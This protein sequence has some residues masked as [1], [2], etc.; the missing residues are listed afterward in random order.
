MKKRIVFCISLLLICLFS[1]FAADSTSSPSSFYKQLPGMFMVNLKSSDIYVSHT[2]NAYWAGYTATSSVSAGGYYDNQ[3]IAVLGIRNATE[4]VTFTVSL[5][6]GNGEWVYLLDPSDNTITRP[7]GIDLIVKGRPDNYVDLYGDGCVVHMGL[8]EAATGTVL[9]PTSSSGKSTS[10]T[11]PASKL[12]SYENTMWMDV[13]LVLPALTDSGS[14]TSSVTNKTYTAKSSDT[15]YTATLKIKVESGDFNDEYTLDLSGIYSSSTDSST[16]YTAVMLVTPTAAAKSLDIAGMAKSGSSIT[17]ANF[18]F[19]TTSVT[20]SDG[21]SDQDAYIFLSSSASG[22]TSGEKFKLRRLRSDGSYSPDDSMYNS[23]TYEAILKSTV[24][25]RTTQVAFDGTTSTSSGTSS[26][27]PID[28]STMTDHQN[29][30]QWVRWYDEGEILIHITQ[31]STEDYTQLA[32]GKY[33]DTIYIHVET[34]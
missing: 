18:S 33:T 6:S 9:S 12:S 22:S 8:Q 20:I 34:V 14:Y 15:P 11:I 5:S 7:F 21:N 2:A 25:G 4:D 17:V 31:D 30:T 24:D 28:A 29:T 16:K 1:I 10:F 32:A 26:Y 23:I 19:S 13:A 27:Y 3:L